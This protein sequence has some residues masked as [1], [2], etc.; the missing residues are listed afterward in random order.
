MSSSLNSSALFWTFTAF[1]IF[2]LIKKIIVTSSFPCSDAFSYWRGVVMRCR[3]GALSLRTKGRRCWVCVWRTA[4]V[5][6]AVT[7]SPSTLGAVFKVV[8]KNKD[9]A[10][11]SSHLQPP[12]GGHCPAVHCCRRLCC[13]TCCHPVHPRFGALYR[14]LRASW[15][16][17]VSSNNFLI[18]VRNDFLQS[19]S[20]KVTFI[21]PL[22]R[23]P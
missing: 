20:L 15:R 19:T 17:Q 1:L 16:T 21:D 4:R 7:V 18:H 2:S 10:A 23:K 3:D 9:W 6:P 14:F 11:P 5:T 13:R 22:H 12:R 8:L